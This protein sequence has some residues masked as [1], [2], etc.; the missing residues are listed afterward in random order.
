MSDESHELSELRARRHQSLS[1]TSSLEESSIEAGA[2]AQAGQVPGPKDQI[3]PTRA[4][5]QLALVVTSCICFVL[6]CL[7]AYDSTQE[8]CHVTFPDS[9]WKL[10]V[11][12]VMSFL[13]VFLAHQLVQSLFEQIRW[14]LVSREKG[15]LL[16]DFD[17]LSSSTSS[18]GAVEH[19]YWN[20]GNMRGISKVLPD[21]RQIWNIQKYFPPYLL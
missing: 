10:G 6:T 21:R 15:V 18:F 17:A 14:K 16:V 13:S 11:L 12:S 7:Y 1:S 8:L 20:A 9:K 19:L 4:H 2:L 3:H 5:K